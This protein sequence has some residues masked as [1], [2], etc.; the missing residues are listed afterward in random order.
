MQP[1]TIILGIVFGSVFSVAVSLATVLLVFG[2]RTGEDSRYVLEIPELWR[3]V[4]MFSLAAVVAG[5]AFLGSLRAAPWR[6]W[7][8]TAMCL[9]LTGIGFY[10]W[11]S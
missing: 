8:I 11:P 6:W 2:L 1:L 9:A 4:V 5:L 7:P 10:Y 3:A